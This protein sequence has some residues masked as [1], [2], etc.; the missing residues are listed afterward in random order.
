MIVTGKTL[1]EQVAKKEQLPVDLVHSIGSFVF[2]T[3]RRESRAFEHLALEL[4]KLGTFILRFN[5]F[6]THFNYLQK[7]IDTKDEETLIL[8]E[9]NPG[10]YEKYKKILR[11]MDEFRQEKKKTRNERY[12]QI[13][14]NIKEH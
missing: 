4:P 10:I 3:F 8:L 9:E 6:Q 5:R 11:K 7:R 14:N 12:E 13:K 2:Q 1:Y